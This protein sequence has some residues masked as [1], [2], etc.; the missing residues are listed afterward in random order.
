MLKWRNFFNSYF[1][2]GEV[3]VGGPAKKYHKDKP[4][5]IYYSTE[6]SL[7][8][9]CHSRRFVILKLSRSI[10]RDHMNKRKC[11]LAE[12]LLKA[13]LKMEAVLVLK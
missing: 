7:L 8:A 1:R 4:S 3:V 6:I 9:R 5:C 10:R 11:F 2:F 13:F 12:A